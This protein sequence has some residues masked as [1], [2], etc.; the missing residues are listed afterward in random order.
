MSMGAAGR[1]WLHRISRNIFASSSS[2][3]T[4]RRKRQRTIPASEPLEALALLSAYSSLM[5]AVG[6][7]P[8]IPAAHRHHEH[9]H[10][11]A[12]HPTNSPVSETGT[13][14]SDPETSI[15]ETASLS[16]TLTNFSSEPLTPSFNLFN[17]SLG[18]LTSVTVSYAATIESSISSTNLSTTSATT[19]TASLSGG[20]QIN[21]LNQPITQP[22]TTLSSAPM[23]A[24]TFG[25]PTDTVTFP[26]LLVSN[27]ATTTY[28]D[29]ASLAFFTSSSGR[30]AVT[31]TMA[32]AATASS[33][34]PNGNLLTSVSTSASS[35]VT[36][37]FTYSTACPTV[38]SIGRIGIH[39]QQTR[40]VVTFAGPVDAAK[41]DDTSNYSVITHSGKTIRIESATFNP[42]TNAVTL[43]PARSLN[44]HYHFKLSVVIPCA[45]PMTP[46]TVVFPFGGKQSLI[47]F[48]NHRGEFVSV[49]NGRIVGFYN[50][51]GQLIPV[52]NRKIEMLKH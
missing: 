26:P 6:P 5:S 12:S 36:I 32:A 9:E 3:R 40:L 20:Y 25:S 44:V 52:H 10:G 49:K 50:H 27:S 41:A 45:N 22:T 37:S 28:T 38:S 8:S 42:A 13:M 19:I 39:R 23:P 16:P 11:A 24:G 30:T 7:P 1:M 17:P 14:S 18:T 4:Y 2:R 31:I 33:Q 43:V 46:G 51:K 29:P 35:S 21:G 47:G 15:P 34:A 48:H